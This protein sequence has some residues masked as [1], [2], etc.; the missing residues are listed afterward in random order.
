MRKYE[1]AIDDVIIS[2][3]TMI[4]YGIDY[5]TCFTILTNR[6]FGIICVVP[7]D[8]SITQYEYN[9]IMDLAKTNIDIWESENKNKGEN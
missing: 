7:F 6:I 3:N 4:A 1:R 9:K 8:N 5:K 2:A